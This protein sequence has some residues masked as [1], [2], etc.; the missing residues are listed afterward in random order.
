MLCGF[1]LDDKA[2]AKAR[3]TRRTTPRASPPEA[4]RQ[5]CGGQKRRCLGA[6]AWLNS[7]APTGFGPLASFVL[8]NLQNSIVMRLKKGAE[9]MCPSIIQGAPSASARRAPG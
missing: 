6:G 1:C 3:M 4:F 2:E 7:E 8:K 9:T 5:E